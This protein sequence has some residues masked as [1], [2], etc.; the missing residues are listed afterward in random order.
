MILSQDFGDGTNSLRIFISSCLSPPFFPSFLYFLSS[1]F[2][3]LSLLSPLFHFPFSH[4]AIVSFLHFHFSTLFTFICVISSARSFQDCNVIARAIRLFHA[5]V[6]P[7]REPG[8]SLMVNDPFMSR[9]HRGD[10]RD[11]S[12][13]CRD[14]RPVARL[15]ALGESRKGHIRSFDQSNVSANH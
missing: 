10:E 15:L 6:F 2:R 14:W 1:I 4:F 11:A 9:R 8:L 12:G 13:Q 5:N 3:F 7:H